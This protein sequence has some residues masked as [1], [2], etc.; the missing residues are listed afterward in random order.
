MAFT[1]PESMGLNNSVKTKC[2]RVIDL[3]NNNNLLPN[4]NNSNRIVAYVTGLSKNDFI[5]PPIINQ[6][7]NKLFEAGQIF[8]NHIPTYNE[9]PQL[10]FQQLLYTW[11]VLGTTYMG[12]GPNGLDKVSL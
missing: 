2:L 4:N 10:K 1:T 8:H 3:L 12:T 5:N 6:S 11:V 9:Q 7:F